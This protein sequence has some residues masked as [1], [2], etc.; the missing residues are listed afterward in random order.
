MGKRLIMLG[1]PGAG[2]GTQ[3]KR[4]AET[5]DVPQVSTGDMLRDA[6]E[7]GTELGLEAARYMAE[8]KLVPDEVVIGI[9]DERLHRADAVEGYI[10]DGFPRTVAQAEALAERGHPIEHAI[11]VDVPVEE[12]VERITGRF[13]C[14]QCGALY[15]ER[16]KRP[17]V[18]HVCDKCGG[19]E[20]KRRADDTEAVVRKRLAEYD[21]KTAPLIDFYRTSGVLARVEGVGSM[22]EVF[23]RIMKVLESDTQA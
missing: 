10:L 14:A 7:A 9:V 12:L 21:E 23:G 4:L 13:S 8:G 15:H 6:R 11:A 5:L 22:D 17:R 19:S 3:A 16:F 18:A 2:K 1:P 20:F